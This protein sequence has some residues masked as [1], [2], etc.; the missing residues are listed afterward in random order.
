[1][2]VV[3]AQFTAR[4]PAMSFQGMNNAGS[5][6]VADFNHD[7]YSDAVFSNFGTGGPGYPSPYDQGTPG[8]TLTYIQGAAS[9]FFNPNAISLNAGG[10]NVSFVTAADFNGDGWMD[11]VCTNANGQGTGSFTIFRN[12]ANG[13]GILTSMGTYQTFSNNAA[14]PE[15]ADVTGDGVPDVIVASFGK[16]NGNQTAIVGNNITIFQQNQDV[17][18]H[19][20]FSFQANPINTL[21]GGGQQFIPTSLV[22]TDLD[23]DGIADIA[24]TVPG[25]PADETQPQPLGSVYVFKGTGAGGF[26]APTIIGSG[27]ALPI[28]IQAA[29]VNGDGYKDLVIANSGDPHSNPEWSSMGIGVILNGTQS[30]G[31]LQFGFTNSFATN[32]YGP[33][34]VAIADFNLDGKQDIAAVN[35]GTQQLFTSPQATVSVYNGNGLGTFSA[36]GIAINTQ[37]GFSGGQ[38]LAVGDFDH[39]GTPDLVVSHD[40]TSAV[41]VLI[42]TATPPPTVAQVQIND[43]S[44]VQ[45]SEVKS[46]EVTFSGPV[47]FT[48]GSAGAATAFQLTRLSDGVNVGLTATLSADEFGRTMATLTFSGLGVD[49]VGLVNGFGS[50]AD[51]R[52]RLTVLSSHVSAGGVA[53][54]GNG[55]AGSDY[56]SPADTAGS[57]AGHQLGLYRLFGDVDGNGTVDAFDVGQLRTAFNTFTGQ[58]GYVSYLD[59]NNDGSVDAIDVGQFRTRFNANLFP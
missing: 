49:S 30:P 40:V 39:N 48:G 44:S 46:I 31:N 28:N 37:T 16:D 13:S 45:R 19:G 35:Y 1:V 33:F 3:P 54:A 55:T 53:L 50:L 17:G 5:V 24:A 47:S 38:Y 18:G 21:T 43:G 11:L 32:V 9:G 36:N 12:T 59:A 23:N 8:T 15:V 58:P 10:T 56:V 20:N 6:A 42:N 41:G 27:G 4:N 26:S 57:G 2:R 22:V 29:D 14:R 51:G 34:A 52:Y 25:V 7:G